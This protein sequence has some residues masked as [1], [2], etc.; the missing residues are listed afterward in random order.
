M[1]DAIK[2]GGEH[3][4]G[5][6][7]TREIETGIMTGIET[8]IVI[9]TTEIEIATETRIEIV[10]RTETTAIATETETITTETGTGTGIEIATGIATE[11][12]IGTTT[13]MTET[14]AVTATEIAIEITEIATEI[15][16]EM[17]V[18]E[19]RGVE[20]VTRMIGV[21]EGILMMI[22]TG[23]G[24]ETGG[25]LMET[26]TGVQ[27]GILM[28]TATGVPKG[29]THFRLGATSTMAPLAAQRK[30]RL[31]VIWML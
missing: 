2:T 27:E 10:I 8:E 6:P 14:V 16:T 7:L 31:A 19:A 9:G 15:T 3:Q 13:K 18:K 28:M 30:T 17:G 22:E 25:I 23:T 11:T 4:T 29:R 12:G 1:S 26:E 20:G 21:P 5:L 24:T